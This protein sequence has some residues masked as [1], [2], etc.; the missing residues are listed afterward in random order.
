MATGEQKKEDAGLQRIDVQS[1]L[2]TALEKD[3]NIEILERLFELQANV[4]DQQAKEAWNH[5]MAE[6]QKL[7]PPIKKTER[8]NISSRRTGASFSYAYAP[9]GEILRI[10]QPVMGPLGLHISFRSRQDPKQ[11]ISNARIS[12]AFGHFEES[13]EVSMPIAGDDGT[14]A[15]PSQKVGIA[16]TYAKRYALLDILGMSPEDDPDAQGTEGAGVQQPRRQGEASGDEP[17]AEGGTWSGTIKNVSQKTGKSGPN[18]DKPWTLYMAHCTDGEK[19]GTFNVKDG[20]FLM[21][22]GTSPVTIVWTMTDRKNKNIISV[23]PYQREPGE[24]G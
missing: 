23:G 9:L 8:A 1:L 20:A 3:S 14:G 10:V 5:A 13:G 22:A 6:F 11:A 17:A 24:E 18:K 16:K 2:Q 12:H 7:C 21:G 19:F 15:N 4:R